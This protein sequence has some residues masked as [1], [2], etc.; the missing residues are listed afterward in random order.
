MKQTTKNRVAAIPPELKAAL[1]TLKVQAKPCDTCIYR[2]D[3]P[4]DLDG[5]EEVVRDKYVG[6]KGYR[7]CHHGD[8][9]CCRG[10]WN[11]HKDDFAAGQI[12]QRLGL[13]EFVHVD[14]DPTETVGEQDE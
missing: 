9:A 2:G 10:F 1:G 3:S 12:A 5:L 8:D 14:I 7:I 6:F 4:L 13:V 11:R